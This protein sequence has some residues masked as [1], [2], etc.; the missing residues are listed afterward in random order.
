MIIQQRLNNKV[1]DKEYYRHMVT[2]PQAVIKAL[3]W[4]KGDEIRSK[5]KGRSLVLTKVR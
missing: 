5:I 1:K 3:K 2:I 4:G